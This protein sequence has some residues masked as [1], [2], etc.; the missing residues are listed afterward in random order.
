MDYSSFTN[1]E[2]EAEY[3]KLTKEISKYDNFQMAKKILMNSLS[4]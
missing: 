4:S 2:L 1:E 3:V